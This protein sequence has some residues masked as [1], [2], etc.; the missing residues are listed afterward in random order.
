MGMVKD[1][2]QSGRRWLAGWLQPSWAGHCLAKAEGLK[3][4]CP[5]GLSALPARSEEMKVCHL[6]LANV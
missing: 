1:E 5:G 2:D 3:G 4:W 6:E